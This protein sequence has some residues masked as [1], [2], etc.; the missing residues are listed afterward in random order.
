MNRIVLAALLFLAL[1]IGARGAEPHPACFLKEGDVWVFHGD[2][3]THAD[4]YRRLCERVFRHYQPDAKVAFLQAGVWG[5]S[6]SDA[7]AQLKAAGRKPTVV[8][9]MTG[10]NNAINGGWVKGMPRDKVLAAYRK[11]LAA[12]VRKNRAEGA[13]VILMSPTLT[14][15]S[16]RRTFFRITGA[17]DLLRDFRIAVEEVAREEGAFYVPVQEEFEAFQESL[18]PKQ[19]L[20]PDGVHPASLGE[21]AIARTLWEHLAFAG[22]MDAGERRLAAPR[23]SADLALVAAARRVEP[24]VKALDFIIAPPTN[25][26]VD[27]VAVTWSLGAL[28]GTEEVTVTGRTAWAL[29]PESGLPPL[30]NGEVTEAVVECRAGPGTALFVVDLS[31]V[32]VFHFSS[33]RLAGVVESAGARPEG[34]R[35][36]AWR[37]ERRGGEL[38]GEF[39]V[40]DGQI[41]SAGDWAY[42][43]DGLNLFLDLRP[44]ERVGDINVDDDVHQLM[45]NFYE[46]PFVAAALRPWLGGGL[47]NAAVCGGE[48]TATGYRI[49]LRLGD[50][51]NLQEPFAL[52]RREWLGLALGVTDADPDENGKAQVVLHE[53]FTAARARDQYASGLAL[54]D[55]KDRWPSDRALNVHV[56]PAR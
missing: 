19:R 20:R 23:P 30:K 16:C 10:M 37:L 4:T 14:D 38:L 8:S 15:E 46:Q 24:W 28:R 25:A 34:G 53:P 1:A 50:R 22:S 29:A 54:I 44:A 13:A 39:E 43:R 17:T 7:A 56:F 49:R 36:C 35:V 51:L 31:A 42:A 6:S 5:S 2:S 12:F 21:Y 11:D 41:H 45:I 48:K 47:D 52:D 40:A 18:G 32:P 33:N 55:L 26:A 27:R 3:I 9:L